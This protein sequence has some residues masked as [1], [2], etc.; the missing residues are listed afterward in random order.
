MSIQ[1]DGICCIV[2]IVYLIFSNT[3][4]NLVKNQKKKKSK[5]PKRLCYIL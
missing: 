3:K 1:L 2:Y 5:I 4:R